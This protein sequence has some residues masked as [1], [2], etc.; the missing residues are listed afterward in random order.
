MLT[1]SQI[2]VNL[3]AEIADTFVAGT[4]QWPDKT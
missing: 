4:R 2:S 3:H 1:I